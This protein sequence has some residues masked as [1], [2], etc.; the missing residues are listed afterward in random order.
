MSDLSA[1][2]RLAVFIACLPDWARTA[3]V[4]AAIGATL[5]G[6]DRAALRALRDEL[7][8][9]IESPEADWLNQ[10]T[11]EI[12]TLGSPTGAPKTYVDGS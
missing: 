11:G 5:T 8:G 7:T 12:T 1:G 2:E 9:G 6:G 3:Q 10:L 4:N